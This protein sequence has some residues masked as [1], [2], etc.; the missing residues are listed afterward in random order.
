MELETQIRP[1]IVSF[2]G[3]IVGAVAGSPLGKDVQIRPDT[4]FGVIAIVVPVNSSKS[5][6]RQRNKPP[7]PSRCVPNGRAEHGCGPISHGSNAIWLFEVFLVEGRLGCAGIIQRPS[8]LFFGGLE[9]VVHH[10]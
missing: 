7:I 10:T 3:F 4:C 9:E 1:V 6:N 2:E 5:G 8:E